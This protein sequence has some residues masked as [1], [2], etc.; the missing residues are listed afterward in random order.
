MRYCLTLRRRLNHKSRW[1][2]PQKLIEFLSKVVVKNNGIVSGVR[3]AL[4]S[5]LGLTR[6]NLEHANQLTNGSCELENLI[7]SGPLKKLSLIS[8][9]AFFAVS[10][11]RWDKNMQ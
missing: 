6:M 5:L 3:K 11:L 7:R 1:Q 10:R 2:H 9:V 4:P 8:S